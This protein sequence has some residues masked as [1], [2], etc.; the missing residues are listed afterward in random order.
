MLAA[1]VPYVVVTSTLAVPE[2][3]AGVVA[4]MVV[5]LTTVTAVAALPPMVTPEAPVN[6]VPVIVTL[7]PPRVGPL[8][9]EIAITVGGGPMPVKM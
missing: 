5:S 6:F 9:G 8:V 4:V 2:L 3:P 1:L 7:V